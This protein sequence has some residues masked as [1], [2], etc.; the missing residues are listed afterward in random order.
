MNDYQFVVTNVEQVS[1]DICTTIARV[2]VNEGGICMVTGPLKS[3]KSLV[4]LY[5]HKK[6]V[7]PLLTERK[8]CFCQPA[9]NRADVP[10]NKIVSRSGGEIDACSFETKSDIKRLFHGHDV[11]ILNEF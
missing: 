10:I 7:M 9:L 5:L 6:F 1:E 11:I 3:G 2:S 8:V 4:A